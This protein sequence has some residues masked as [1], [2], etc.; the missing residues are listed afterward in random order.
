MPTKENSSKK[1]DFGASV[2]KLVGVRK[3]SANL[4]D[5]PLSAR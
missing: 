3:A 1:V 2:P 4:T 5:L